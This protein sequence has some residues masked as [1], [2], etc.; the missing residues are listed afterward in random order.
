M[1]TPSDWHSDSL[2]LTTHTHTHTQ[3]DQPKPTGSDLP[4][5]IHAIVLS[6]TDYATHRHAYDSA[7]K[8]RKAPTGWPKNRHISICLVLNW[9]NFVKFQPNFIIFGKL[10]PEY[11][12]L[13]NNA[14]TVHNTYCVFLHYFVEI[15]LSVIC[16]LSRWNL[17]T[18]YVGKHLNSVS[19]TKL[20]WSVYK[21]CSICLP[22]NQKNYK[23]RL[24]FHKAI[25][26]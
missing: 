25:S 13:K 1:P 21:Q 22:L 16:V 12:S 14:Y 23:I 20:Y 17:L 3:L 8:I 5:M 19:H 18:N 2:W 26:I 6:V 11:I 15:I 7:T 10:T 24:R 4:I 9:Y